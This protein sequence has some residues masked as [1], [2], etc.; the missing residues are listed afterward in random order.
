MVGLTALIVL[1]GAAGWIVYTSVTKAPAVVAAVVTGF[2]ALFGLFFQR[3]LEHQRED[4]RERRQRVAPIYDELVHKFYDPSQLTEGDLKQFFE[5]LAQSLIVWGSEPVIQAFNRFRSAVT[6]DDDG[7]GNLLAYEELLYA[8]RTD[9]G[10]SSEKLGKG[11]LLRVYINDI[12][13]HLPR[14]A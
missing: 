3:Y 13:E 6:A 2:A 5:A 7:L 12:D 4:V 8:I 14:E 11:D 1:V 9:L 10:N